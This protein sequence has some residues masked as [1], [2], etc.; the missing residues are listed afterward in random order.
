MEERS[1]LVY[2]IL[3]TPG[4]GRRQ[5]IDDLAINGLAPGD[6]PALLVPVAEVGGEASIPISTWALEGEA[7]HAT[8]PDGASHVFMVAD[9]RLNPVD[10]VEALV[11]WLPA[12]GARIGRV[13]TVVDCNFGHAHP[14]LFPWFEACVHFSDVVFL[15]NAAGVPGSWLVEF[16]KHF[17]KKYFPCLFER[18]KNGEVANPALVL[19]TL[20][21][22]MTPA[23]EDEFS[24]GPA[25]A[26]DFDDD[27]DD[28][29]FDD[30]EPEEEPLEDPYF[31]RNGG[32]G[33]RSQV[34]PDIS[35]FLPPSA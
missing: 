17:K 10:Q 20:A 35:P 5:I 26:V 9:S 18:P 25:V 34:V 32:G 6:K 21:L 16:E 12:T 30:I 14:D 27:E 3:G 7:I 15:T 28:A 31:V 2:F 19:E 24:L 22:R 1:T 29:D 23:F 11:A 33:N 13:F 8:I 4:S